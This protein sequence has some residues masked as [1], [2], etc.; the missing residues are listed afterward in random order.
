MPTVEERLAYLE[1][2]VEE[3]GRGMAG[4][5]DAVIQFTHRMD[6]L[7]LKIGR[8]REELVGRIDAVDLKIDRFREELVGRIDAVDLKIDRFREEL[9]G[10]IDA[11]EQKLAGRIDGLDQKL[12]RHFLWLVGMQVTVLLAVVGALLRG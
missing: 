6:G 4:L 2:R 8:F 1:G 7:D 12:S 10:R 11:A 9:A 3:H 5:G